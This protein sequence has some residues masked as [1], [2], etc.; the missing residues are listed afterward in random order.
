MHHGSFSHI[1]NVLVTAYTLFHL[2]YILKGLLVFPKLVLPV[3]KQ[4]PVY[5][6][7]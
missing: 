4:H 7:D 6:S 3:H 1:S 2:T 5:E